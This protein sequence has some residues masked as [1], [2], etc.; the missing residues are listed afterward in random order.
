VHKTGIIISNVDQ[1]HTKKTRRS[2]MPSST[3]ESNT[4]INEPETFI[5]ETMCREALEAYSTGEIHT[6]IGLWQESLDFSNQFQKNDPRL[7]TNLNNA[8]ILNFL[9]KSYQDSEK[10]FRLAL[11]EWQK[12]RIW[13]STM[14]VSSTARSSLYHHRL[15]VRH[16]DQFTDHSR[17][18]YCNWIDGSEAI[19]AY[20]LAIVLI[21]TNR[22]DQ[23]VNFLT[24]ALKLREQA[25]G[26]SNPELAVILQAIA[27]FS[28][29][30][31][32]SANY[33]ER[34]KTARNNPTR[35]ALER[36]DSDQPQSMNDT[37]RL[38]GSICLTAM[39]SEHAFS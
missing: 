17:T 14:E 39:L 1:A 4:K 35:S 33:Q 36:W 31:I 29:D 9:N 20:N 18:R 23:G 30:E 11:E 6:A 15:E 10:S 3:Q 26:D 16:Q 27:R 34:S 19:T 24:K 37:R 25:F 12:A 21:C 7:C 22:K 5:W 2:G 8:G 32:L 38:L 28:D 13:T